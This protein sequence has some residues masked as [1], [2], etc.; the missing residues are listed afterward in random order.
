MG[1]VVELSLDLIARAARA[2]TALLG[3]ILS[4]RITALNH[5]ILDDAMEACPIVEAFV[6]KLLE[7]LDMSR[8]NIRPEFED[9][10]AL[11]RFDNGNLAH[12][13]CLSYFLSLSAGRMIADLM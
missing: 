6:S 2:P 3:F 11:G 4:V 8:R 5:K 9:H 10:F 12:R 13:K 7:V 1:L